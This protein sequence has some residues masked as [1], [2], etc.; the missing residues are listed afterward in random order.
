MQ[1][2]LEAFANDDLRTDVEPEERTPEHKRIYEWSNKLQEKMEQ[3]LNK[4][5]QELLEE[6]LLSLA[7]ESSCYAQARFI[8]GYQLGA[9]M[10]MEIFWN[11]ESC[12]RTGRG[13]DLSA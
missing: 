8:R 10:M 2:I 7:S 9:L 1:Q 3:T 13:G 4:E 11:R 5:E 6:L 12:V